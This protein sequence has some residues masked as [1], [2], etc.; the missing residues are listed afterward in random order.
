MDSISSHR[1]HPILTTALFTLVS[2]LVMPGCG[3]PD[4]PAPVAHEKEPDPTPTWV[5]ALTCRECHAP[6]YELWKGSHHDLA[7]QPA[8]WDTVRGDFNDAELTHFGITSR[9]FTRDGRFFVHT[10]GPDGTFDDFEVA[11]VFGVIPL[12]QYLVG[13]PDGRYQTL[14]TFWDTRPEEEGGQRWFHIYPD[15]RIAPDDVLYWT[16]PNQNWNF[17]CAEC[18][19]TNLQRNYDLKHDR[20]DT[21]WSEINVAC[22]ACHGPGSRHV[23]WARRHE[24]DPPEH[25]A[26]LSFKNMALDFSLS[27][28]FDDAWVFDEGEVTA[29]RAQPRTEHTQLENC[30][31]CHSRRIT[32]NDTLPPGAPLL[33]THHPRL[34]EE[35]LYYADGQI[36]DEV[37]VYGSFV[38]SAMHK[39]GVTCSDCHDSHGLQLRAEGNALCARCHQPEAFDTPEHHFHEANTPGAGCVEC[40]MPVRTYMVVDPRHDHSLRI[41]RPD[42]TL[43]IG[44]PNTCND[45]HDD[46]TARWALEAVQEWY[47]EDRRNE[48][49][50]GEILRAGQRGVPGASTALAALI[51]DDEQPGIARATA[52]SLLDPL[53]DPQTLPA[54]EAALKDDDPQVRTAAVDALEPFP[55]QQ[56]ER[57]GAPLLVDPL[58]AVRMTAAFTLA[59]VADDLLTPEQR[60]NRAEA[61]REYIAVQMTNAERPESHLNLGILHARRGNWSQAEDACRTALRLNP[62]FIPAYVNLADLYRSMGRD[63]EGERVLREALAIR[64]NDAAVH[65]AL[66]LLLVRTGRQAEALEHLQQA[67]RLQP[68]AVR[69]RYVFAV[70]LA[71]LGERARAIDELEN[72]LRE[73]PDDR[74]LLFAT[75][76]YCQ[77]AGDLDR[78][79]ECAEHL[80]R[81]SPQDQNAQQLLNHLRSERG[82]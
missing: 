37:Y 73:H 10:E 27:D 70:A 79:I 50:Y 21:I 43:T 62:T 71:S 28:P 6:E 8:L 31:P 24:D 15:E 42:L 48:R 23:Q 47:G 19:S 75:V 1:S 17:M 81:L 76:S 56:R 80:V 77:Q 3:S 14:P 52:L 46:Q 32:L 20:F 9:F 4:D 41:P 51:R 69:Y 55:P 72:A 2:L 5:G 39:A 34:L 16:G 68:Y 33:D 7:M 44:V 53:N 54:I 35:R 12:E 49:H 64:P 67:T 13:F 25:L 45:C 40:H 11:Y 78:A 61:V 65:H 66:G 38:Q 63:D 36:L 59:D 58:L 26:E 30:A 57:L 74:D 60:R 22:E 18:H 29:H 82:N